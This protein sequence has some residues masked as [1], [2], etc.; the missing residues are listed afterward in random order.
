M[1]IVAKEPEGQFVAAPE[2]L[3]QAVCVDVIDL[4]QELNKF[5]D[6]PTMQPKVRIVWQ[7]DEVNPESGRRFEVAEKYTLSLHE[8]AALRHHLEAWRGKAFTDQELKGFDL[9]VLKGVN[10]QLQIVHK[11]GSKG[12]T[13]AN[14][15]AIVP[16]GKNTSKI[17]PLNY[18]RRVPKPASQHE[19]AGSHSAPGGDD[20]QAD[21]SDVPFGLLLPFIL[22]AILGL[23]ALA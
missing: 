4:G 6:P 19:S 5:R 20:F 15:Q 13:F 22:P 21:D 8:K 10:C 11:L 3:H 12:G 23:G 17:V 1:P 18:E 9:E 2:G 14:V 7:I 16:I